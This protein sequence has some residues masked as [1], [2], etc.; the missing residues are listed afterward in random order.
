[1]PIQTAID[2]ISNSQGSPFGFKNRIIN[3][4]MVIDQRNAGSS[5]TPTN[6]TFSLDRWQFE[7]TQSSKITTIQS[8]D[9][10]TGFSNS[11]L[12][13]S[14]SS[15]SIGSSDSFLLRQHIEGY[16]WFDMSYGTSLA[17]SATLSFW[18]KSS[19]TGTFGGAFRNNNNDRS[20]LYQYTINQANTWEYKTITI[21]G[22]TTGTWEKTNQ[23]GVTVY[24]GL[25]T[26]STTNPNS[27][28]GGWISGNYQTVTS[29]T[30]LVGTNGA[31]WYVT[32]V[33]VEKGS[34]ATSFDFRPYTTELALCQRYYTKF[35]PF[36]LEAYQGA[37][38]YVRALNTVVPL[39]VE[40]R[41]TP[42][43]TVVTAGSSSIIRP[44]DTSYSGLNP[45]SAKHLNA[46]LETNNTTGTASISGRVEAFDAEM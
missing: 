5:V 3:G 19:L 11:L 33:Q 12:V 28:T 46:F 32:G 21:P 31:T 41:T 9:A 45:I 38:G 29:Q 42:T 22:D 15:Y 27:F 44:T 23:R 30:S 37:G 2:S 25:A 8:S 10:P 16:N 1:M 17:K 34:Q 36:S 14:S 18:V 4:G 35:G 39:P 13:T 26:G 24:F 43:R 6:G 7:V 20:Y 40:M